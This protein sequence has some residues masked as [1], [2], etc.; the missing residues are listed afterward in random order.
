MSAKDD[1]KA[2][3][4][5]GRKMTGEDKDA[6]IKKLADALKTLGDVSEKEITRLS[7]A[8]EDAANKMISNELRDKY[9]A[10]L[11]KVNTEGE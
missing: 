7:E 5:Y 9:L 8:L 10:I 6:R 3:V 4:E 2:A 1:A 11:T